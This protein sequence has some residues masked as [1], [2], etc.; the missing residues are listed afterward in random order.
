MNENREDSPNYLICLG[1]PFDGASVTIGTKFKNVL[2]ATTKGRHSMWIDNR[3]RYVYDP[4]FDVL[5]YD[6]GNQTP[7]YYVDDDD[8]GDEDDWCD[9][10][11]YRDL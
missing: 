7:P 9:L 11:D 6:N 2:L 4:D 5:V 8:Y 10:E 3:H 1:G